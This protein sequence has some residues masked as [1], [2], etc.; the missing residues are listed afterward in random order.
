[1]KHARD[2]YN[3]IQDPA[4]LIPEDEPVFLLR[5]Q[6]VLASDAV[7][8]YALRACLE[9]RIEVAFLSFQQAKR[10]EGWEPRKLPDIAEEALPPIPYIDKA[11]G[12]V[13]AC[14][15]I[16]LVGAKGMLG[17]YEVKIGIGNLAMTI[18]RKELDVAVKK[19][20]EKYPFDESLADGI[21]ATVLKALFP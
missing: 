11:D 14:K 17:S 8:Y 21:V 9:G 16:H 18:D 3:R 6:D 19:V 2:D 4:G 15:N 1:M 7:R 20:Q 13:P 5:G 12:L 10:M